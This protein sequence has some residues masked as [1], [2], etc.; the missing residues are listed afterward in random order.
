MKREEI[1]E[2]VNEFLV[3]ELEIEEDKIKPES[4]LKEEVGIDSLDLVDIVVIGYT[5][6]QIEVR[7]AD[8]VVVESNLD[9]LVRGLGSIHELVRET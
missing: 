8:N 9:T 4:L 6:V 7:L 5:K 2:K 3:E 1:V